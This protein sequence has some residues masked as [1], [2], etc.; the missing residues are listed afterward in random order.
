VPYAVELHKPTVA[1][2]PHSVP[3]EKVQCAARRG[4]CRLAAGTIPLRSVARHR[5][6]D[7]LERQPREPCS[8]RDTGFELQH[9]GVFVY[10]AE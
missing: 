2:L 7:I 6:A 9:P 1:A 4:H 10:A 5:Q 8:I 3:F